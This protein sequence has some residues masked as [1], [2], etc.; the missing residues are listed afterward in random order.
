MNDHVEHRKDRIQWIDLVV[1][2]DVFVEEFQEWNGT[3]LERLL[4]N[5]STIVDKNF[6]NKFSTTLNSAKLVNK[7]SLLFP[8]DSPMEIPNSP[9]R[10]YKS[11][12]KRSAGRNTDNTKPIN[13]V[14][15]SSD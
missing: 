6:A 11:H 8:K 12:S 9:D 15:Y 3:F 13:A 14:E 1:S 2:L 5:F 4:W 10:Y 7:S